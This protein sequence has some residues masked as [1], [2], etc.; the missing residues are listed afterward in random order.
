M[1]SSETGSPSIDITVRNLLGINCVRR[2]ARHRSTGQRRR[3]PRLVSRDRRNRPG[4]PAAALT[5]YPQQIGIAPLPGREQALGPVESFPFEYA[6]Y[7]ARE[8]LT[9]EQVTLLLGRR[10]VAER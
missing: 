8:H 1:H 6:V 3:Q 10:V 5:E 2:T 9:G 7:L 4:R